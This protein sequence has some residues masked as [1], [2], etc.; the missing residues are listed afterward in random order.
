MRLL[1]SF[2]DPVEITL[3][4]WLVWPLVAIEVILLPERLWNLAVWATHHAA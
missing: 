1:R 4:G 2:C 3:P